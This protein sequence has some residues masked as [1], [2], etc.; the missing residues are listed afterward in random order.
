MSRGKLR[1]LNCPACRAWHW[2]YPDECLIGGQGPYCSR[3]ILRGKKVLLLKTI[4]NGR[5]PYK[6]EALPPGKL[7]TRPVGFKTRW[8]S[9]HHGGD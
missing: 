6:S 9:P 3:C 1:S 5:Q 7:Y 2:I 4:R 8:R